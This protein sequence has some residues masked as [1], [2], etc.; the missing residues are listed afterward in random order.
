MPL[1]FNEE[2]SHEN[3]FDSNWNGSE[4]DGGGHLGYRARRGSAVPAA[5]SGRVEA[6]GRA[7]LW[8]SAQ[9]APPPPPPQDQGGWRRLGGPSVA[10]NADP[11][12][13]PPPSYSQPP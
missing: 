11:N 12:Q 9:A 2:A 8:L 6:G 5:G 4:H 13:G 3:D 7:P 10:D 1:L